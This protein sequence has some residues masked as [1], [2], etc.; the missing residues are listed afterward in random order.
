MTPRSKRSACNRGKV[1]INY[2]KLLRVSEGT[3]NRWSG[4][5]LQP[6]ALTN[7]HWARVVGYGLFLYYVIHKDL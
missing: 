6:L 2:L 4:L 7:P 3:L 5:H 1:N